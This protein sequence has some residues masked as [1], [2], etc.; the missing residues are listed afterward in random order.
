MDLMVYV[1][2]DAVVTWMTFVH[3]EEKI[4]SWNAFQDM[5]I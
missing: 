4:I 5:N 1:V 2:L 3:V